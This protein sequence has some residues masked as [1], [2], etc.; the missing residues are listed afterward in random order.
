MGMIGVIIVGEDT[1]NLKDISQL[2]LLPA[3]DKQ[4]RKI[5]G[6]GKFISP[7]A[8]PKQGPQGQ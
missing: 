6:E 3:A 4:L 2:A 1:H 8:K 5:L 7:M